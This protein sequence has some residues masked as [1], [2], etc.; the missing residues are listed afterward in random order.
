MELMDKTEQQVLPVRQEHKVQLVQLDKQARKAR[1]V[2]LVLRDLK[3]HL[4]QQV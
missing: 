1:K 2:L 3:D 4:V